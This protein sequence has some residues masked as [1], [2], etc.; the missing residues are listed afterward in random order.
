MKVKGRKK[1]YLSDLELDLAYNLRSYGAGI[2]KICAILG[3][4]APTLYRMRM[5]SVYVDA[6]WTEAKL[7]FERIDK[8]GKAFL[9]YD[10]KKN[11]L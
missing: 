11:N 9:K 3:I 8:L 6:V 1:V 10:T 5:E 2:T 4:T 7:N